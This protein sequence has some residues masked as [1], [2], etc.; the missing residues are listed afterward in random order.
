M[1]TE[2][3]AEKPTGTVGLDFRSSG[4]WAS[5]LT[6]TGGVELNLSQ[7][8]LTPKSPSCATREVDESGA[9]VLEF[10]GLLE[11]LGDG[12]R[13]VMQGRGERPDAILRALL[14]AAL[15][16]T[17][18]VVGSRPALAVVVPSSIDEIHRQVIDRYA[19]ACGWHD[20]RTVDSDVA[21]AR[22]TLP[23]STAGYYLLVTAGERFTEVSMVHWGNGRLRVLS[24]GHEDGVSEGRL[25]SGVMAH[26]WSSAGGRDG[27]GRH[28][29]IP[30]MSSVWAWLKDHAEEIREQLC[31][32]ETAKLT[33]P[34]G[35]VSDTEVEVQFQRRELARSVE[36]MVRRLEDRLRRL[37]DE[38]CMES[39][40][41]RGCVVTG[42]LFRQAFL[43]GSLSPL[44]KMFDVTISGDD[45]QA[46]GAARLVR[47][48]ALHGDA[49]R[50]PNGAGEAR[51]RGF[52]VREEPI[53][54]SMFGTP[55]RT[56]G[57]A[58]EIIYR[59]RSL[60]DAG[61]T[62]EARRE[63]Q[64][65]KSYVDGLA[66]ALGGSDEILGEGLNG[67]GTTTAVSNAQRISSASEEGR[68]HNADPGREARRAYLGA[69]E[70]I[71]LAEQ[72]LREGLTRP[73]I[74]AGHKAYASS[75]DERIFNAMMEIH[76]RVVR[77]TKPHVDNFQ[78][79]REWLL[80]AYDH[81]PRHE[82]V[83]ETLK[84]RY[85]T[86]LQQ[87]LALVT[88]GRGERPVVFEEAARVIEEL[89]NL[90]EI[91]ARFDDV[92]QRI[93]LGREE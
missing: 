75:Q 26:L 3:P 59:T 20:V 4:I 78:E 85:L 72:L 18:A 89:R 36:A 53:G 42:R 84:A 17:R 70:H 35:I 76:F 83:R 56:G 21:L 64:V 25:D 6:A 67:R 55:A 66:M 74:D 37:L 22:A 47:E 2:N 54:L 28:V 1:V 82:G 69:R 5:F 43:L 88:E 80:C 49:G 50:V 91:D 14:K 92:S 86:H 57:L 48:I 77:R 68:E 93:R 30:S 41:I 32:H 65:L 73:A 44:A 29:R 81:D 87:M 16:G 58:D 38:C 51:L 33:V 45:V 13:V 7:A 15:Q 60:A 19:N 31:L 71:K 62:Q 34:D 52:V 10:S 39:E 61:Q 40:Q 63:L 90:V 27:D 11:R 12:N 24:R 79:H 8:E 23:G 9:V 46:R